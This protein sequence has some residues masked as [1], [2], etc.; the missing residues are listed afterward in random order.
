MAL[1]T[2]DST[3]KS[4]IKL[5]DKE[6]KGKICTNHLGFTEEEC[7][8]ELRHCV[9][10]FYYNS[11]T[12]K[13]DFRCKIKGRRNLI[14]LR[15]AIDKDLLLNFQTQAV[16]LKPVEEPMKGYH[17]RVY[18]HILVEQDIPDHFLETL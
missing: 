17:C 12:I 15:F 18:H 6:L 10:Y 9:R 16:H 8:A 11:A 13:V 7:L 2:E 1:S 14:L 4:L 3:S 5:F